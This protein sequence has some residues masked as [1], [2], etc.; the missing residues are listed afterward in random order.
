MRH[1]TRKSD[2]QAKS[3]CLAGGYRCATM[4]INIIKTNI[5]DAEQIK[6]LLFK[7][8]DPKCA[9]DI[10][11]GG[12]RCTMKNACCVS[13][14]YW[15]L[16]RSVRQLNQ[17]Q[18]A[19]RLGIS[20][21]HLSNIEHNNVLVSLKSCWGPSANVLGRSLEATAGQGCCGRVGWS[22]LYRWR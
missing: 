5:F 19:E 6:T 14:A 15:K 12:G 7:C 1:K 11:S 13:G 21:T 2:T 16:L 4:Y 8:F 22:A 3:K 9:R 18:P 20:Q 17:H 10:E